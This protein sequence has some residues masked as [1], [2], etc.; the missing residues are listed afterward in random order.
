VFSFPRAFQVA[1][2]IVIVLLGSA[3]ARGDRSASSADG[4]ADTSTSDG[5]PDASNNDA[6]G[7]DA[8]VGD[9]NGGDAPANDSS[10]RDTSSADGASVDRVGKDV[11]HD[12]PGIFL[13]GTQ[14]NEL[15]IPFRSSSGCGDCHGLYAD[16]DSDT[17]WKGTMM[18][19]A[20]RDPLFHAA[21]TIARQDEPVSGDLCIRCHAPRAWLFGRSEPALISN[22]EPNDF[23]SVQCDF[24]HRLTTGPTGTPY[25]G[26][27][28]YFVADDFTRRGPIRDSLAPHDFQYSAYHEESRLCG[29]CHDVSNPLK[30]NF[31]LERTYTEWLTSAFASEGQ[32][33]QSCHMPSQRGFACGAPEMPE[34]DV[35]TH[36]F[37][38]GNYWMP[39]VLAGEHP[40]LSN[41]AA[42]EKSAKNAEA[43]LRNSADLT[44]ELPARVTAGEKLAFRVRVEN[45]TGHKLPTG[46]PEGRRMWLEVEV[47]GDGAASLFH[48][49]AYDKTTATRASDPQLRTYEVRMAAK[50][51]EGFHFM[52]QDEVLQDNR[53]P[54]RGF[55]PRPD[56]KPVGRDYPIVPSAD[57]GG[58]PTLAHWDDAPYELTIPKTALGTMVVRATLWY[59]TTSREYVEALK[60]DNVTDDYGKKM[61]EI[62]ER[63]D[64]ALPFGM[65]NTTG[66]IAV[67]PA[68]PDPEP[69]VEPAPEPSAEGGARDRDAARDSSTASEPTPEG[70]SGVDGPAADGEVVGGG[71]ACSLAVA[72]G[73]AY[74]A[75]FGFAFGVI[76]L[77]GRSRGRAKR[78]FDEGDAWM[79]V[80]RSIVGRR[81]LERVRRR[82]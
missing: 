30:G 60:N 6:R 16:Y 32:S 13:P 64:R 75:V 12:V 65:A 2:L 11:P 17:T 62:W 59:Q 54:P 56:T 29:L 81:R 24:C 72:R 80:A 55:M 61:L 27:G 21:L 3:D 45:K 5:A 50:G 42:Y 10:G 46:Y 25:I 76:G 63:Y 51:V 52:L 82:R 68:P 18:A 57:A 69:V 53:I 31:A 79:G 26:N 66:S 23:E 15:T 33:C 49:G 71:C 14:P 74:H 20:A 35:H 48:S 39:R 4:G 7:A 44:L 37:A 1:S 70:G 78:R 38:G 77:L 43:K 19:N 36:E 28:Q 73:P 40:E 9:T 34:R 8:S 67:E 41:G 22:L 58:A 47:T